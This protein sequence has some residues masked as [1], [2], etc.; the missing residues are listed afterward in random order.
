ME[1]AKG[2]ITTFM[3][4]IS[5]CSLYSKEHASLDDLAQRSLSFLEQLMKDVD[6]YEIMIVD[7]DLILNKT[8]V[9]DV[10]TH[11]KQLVRKMKRKG[12]SRIDFL[13]GVKQSEMRG[14]ITDLANPN[15]G[16]RKYSHIRSGVVDVCLGGLKIDADIDFNDLFNFTATQVDTVKELYDNWSPYKKLNIA[17][18]E[19]IVINFI[20]TFKKEANILQLI[21]PVKTYSEYTYTHATNVAVLSMFQAELLG[22]K[23]ALLR[24]VGIAALLHDVG[25]LFISKEILE[26]KA[27]LQEE[28]WEEIKRHPYYG[29]RYLSKLE[30][31]T[32]LAPVVAFEHHLKYDGS[33]Y[34]A[35]RINNNQ[36]HVFSQIV[37]ISDYF[38][39]LRSK[40]PYR[41]SV[42]MKEVL[43]IMKNEENGVFNPLLLD[44]FIKGLQ[45]SFSD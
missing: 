35:K 40:R 2:F 39:A 44:S 31:I 17:G 15:E 3:S 8:I 29:A 20:V 26:K 21:S 34:P 28:E 38:D 14:L 5:N 33:G 11:G 12:L 32:R 19:E 45:L 4:A 37:A 18:L 6:S 1:T 13:K 10:G 24:D 22:V 43:M 27:E 23:D 42:D 41:L 7:D 25:K 36:Q 9:R 30:G 16:L